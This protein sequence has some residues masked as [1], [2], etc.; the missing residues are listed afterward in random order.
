MENVEKIVENLKRIANRYRI[1]YAVLFGSALKKK[2]PKDIDIAVKLQD[3]VGKNEAIKTI[4]ILVDKLE[5]E[6]LDI[7]VINFAPFSLLYDI[8]T[9]GKLIYFR[10]KKEFYRDAFTVLKFYDDWK[11]MVRSFK[12]RE[13]EKVKV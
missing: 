12:K 1:R 6:K 10:D 7:V 9:Q 8:Y 13:L 3:G 2:K 4:K 11:H 5:S